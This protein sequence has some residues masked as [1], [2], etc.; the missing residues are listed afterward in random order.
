MSRSV[1]LNTTAT[2]NTSCIYILALRQENIVGPIAHVHGDKKME[3][4]H[5]KCT[6]TGELEIR[7][8]QFMLKPYRLP[9]TIMQKV[10]S[11]TDA[12]AE[13]RT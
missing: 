7:K 10:N 8:L 3:Y 12:S 1:G 2:V 13:A 5:K 11:N 9:F 4:G 6:P